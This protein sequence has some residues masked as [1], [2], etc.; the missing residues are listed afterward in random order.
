VSG[1]LPASALP[2]A[3]D[4]RIDE[5]ELRKLVGFLASVRG[6]GGIVCNSDA[7]DVW[8]LTRKEQRRVVEIHAEECGSRVPVIAGVAAESVWEATDQMTDARDAGAAGVLVFP[9]RDA[10]GAPGSVVV[11]YFEQIARAVDIP[12]IVFQ[13]NSGSPYTYAPETLARLARISNVVGIKDAVDDIKA[14]EMD[15]RALAAAPRRVAHLNALDRT[16]LA[17]FVFGTD[18]S[19]IGFGNIVP[20]WVVEMIDAM[21]RGDLSGAKAVDD[22]LFRLVEVFYQTPGRPVHSAIKEALFMTGVLSKPS[23]SRRPMRALTP[24]DRTS[25]R[26]ALDASGLA[27][28]YESLLSTKRAEVALSG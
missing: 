7:G 11:D 14:Y 17:G 20:H 19:L 9:P 24:E 15:A 1:L 8:A 21:K 22:R 13:Y 10:G 6:V 4:E 5:T 28:F 26:S 25:I 23:N 16:L 3:E 2:F 12:I 18:G 27:K